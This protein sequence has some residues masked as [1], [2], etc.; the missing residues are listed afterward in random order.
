MKCM[1]AKHWHLS[2]LT[3]CET[4]HMKS[5]W[6]LSSGDEMRE[7][8]VILNNAIGRRGL[9]NVYGF[10]ISIQQATSIKSQ[11]AVI[12]IIVE[13]N[14]KWWIGILDRLPHPKLMCLFNSLSSFTMS[15]LLG[16]NLYINCRDSMSVRLDILCNSL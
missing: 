14:P 10:Q 9:Q 7:D 4:N 5:D 3:H 8:I 15:P 11:I 1:K 13:I 16:A 6:K 2:Y 12:Y